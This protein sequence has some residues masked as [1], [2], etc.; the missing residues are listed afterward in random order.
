L[1]AALLCLKGYEY[2]LDFQDKIVPVVNFEVGPGEGS[3]GE[4]FWVFTGSRLVCMRSPYDR[5]WAGTIFMRL[6][7]APSLKWVFAVSGFF[8]LLFL[9]GLS[10]TDYADRRSWPPIYCP[11]D[12][13]L[14]ML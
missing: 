3:A 13:A 8:L 10:M 11:V 12:R 7:G 1:V 9:Y 4:L 2:Y 5:S 6:K 14:A